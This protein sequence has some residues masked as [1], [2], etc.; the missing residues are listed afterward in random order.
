MVKRITNLTDGDIEAVCKIL[1]GWPMGGKL[2]WKNLVQAL[3]Q[4]L[5]KKWS[6]QAL[7]KHTRIAQAF[8]LKKKSMS[9][10]P[11]PE[12]KTIP[13]DVRKA[14]ES[15]MRLE[16]EIERLKKEN[17]G[18]L[19]QFRRWSVNAESH[20]IT[21]ALLNSPLSTSYKRRTRRELQ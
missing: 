20:G 17:D 5:D 3:E 8:K 1:D 18:F 16:A 12:D 10:T 2:T 13:A 11:P 6:R 9:K 15:I 14:N 21:E 7:D 4:R 19:Q